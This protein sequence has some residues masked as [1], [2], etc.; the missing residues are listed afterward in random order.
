[1]ESIEFDDLMVCLLVT[2]PENLT[3]THS[4]P[5]LVRSFELLTRHGREL[6]LTPVA[7]RKHFIIAAF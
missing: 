5:K 2:R 3:I 1:M 7:A 6:S 4:P